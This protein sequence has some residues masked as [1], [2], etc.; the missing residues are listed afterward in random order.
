MPVCWSC[1][2]LNCIYNM[3]FHWLSTVGSQVSRFWQRGVVHACACALVQGGG[4]E[5]K[6]GRTIAPKKWWEELQQKTS[7]VSDM[8]FL[9]V[10]EAH[11]PTNSH[12]LS[13]SFPFCSPVLLTAENDSS[14]G[15]FY[16]MQITS[17]MVKRTHTY[18]WRDT[19]VQRH[20]TKHQRNELRKENWQ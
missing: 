6:G 9:I 11:S 1:K 3:T 8:L 13:H 20:W 18:T 17:Y 10:P 15:S 4:E 19:E 12:W 5:E 14:F 7:S 16:D 2:K